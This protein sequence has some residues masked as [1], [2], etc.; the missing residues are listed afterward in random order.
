MRD[1]KKREAF[2]FRTLKKSIYRNWLQTQTYTDRFQNSAT[3]IIDE[4]C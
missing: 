2:P 1:I 3:N 4:R